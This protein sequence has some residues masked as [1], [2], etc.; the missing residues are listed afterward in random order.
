VN[1]AFCEFSRLFC[2]LSNCCVRA[3]ALVAVSPRA[4]GSGGANRVERALS[5]REK[6]KTT[7]RCWNA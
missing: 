2:A 6:P 3:A 5:T 7:D 1:S 4:A